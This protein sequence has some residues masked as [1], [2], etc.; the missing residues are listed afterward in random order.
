MQM[1]HLKLYKSKSM[2]FINDFIC[3]LLDMQKSFTPIQYVFVI[4]AWYMKYNSIIE[5]FT[6][7]YL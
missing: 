1:L 2:I 3:L 6:D 5:I 4:C 7:P